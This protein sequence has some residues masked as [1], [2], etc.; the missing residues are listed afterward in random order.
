MAKLHSL[1]T[2]LL[3][4]FFTLFQAYPIPAKPKPT[5][6][7]LDLIPTDLISGF[8]SQI[9]NQTDRIQKLV[10]SSKSRA[11]YLETISNPSASKVHL[12]VNRFN[13]LYAVKVTLGARRESRMLEVDTA[14]GLIWTQCQ[15]CGYC[16]NQSDPIFDGRRSLTYRKLPSR[17][18]S[19]RTPPY[20]RANGQCTYGLSYG[21]AAITRGVLSLETFWFP[22]GNSFYPKKDV[23]FGCSNDNQNFNFDKSRR[24]SG[25]FGMS[26]SS[27][28]F[29]KQTDKVILG[30]FSYCLV[31]IANTRNATTS[32]LSF[33]S[34]V[35]VPRNARS[36]PFASVTSSPQYYLNLLDI[37]VAGNRIK[38][39][40]GTFSL[41]PG[42]TGGCIIDTGTSATLIA[43]P[44]YG[45]VIEAFQK[46]FQPFNLRKLRRS[47]F[48]V[49]FELRKSFNEFPSM[50]FHFQGGDLVVQPKY[51]HFFDTVANFFCVAVLKGST[52]TIL[53]SLQQQDVRFVYDLNRNVLFF[54]PETC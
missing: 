24:I 40:P 4:F 15:P 27:E 42:G 9:P 45:R 20:K 18:R 33:G 14:T 31:A 7:S 3:L 8:D 22:F 37:S 52:K 50:T 16:F 29:V 30:R 38:F 2:S 36:T 54:A 46:Y 25:I 35:Y 23:V 13:S 5:G 41:K 51:V 28:S 32:V 44:A 48:D 17:H 12:I 43:P 1:D 6:F 53:G 26:R 10:E 34:D 47:G 19:C 39:P 49:C 21:G 11:H